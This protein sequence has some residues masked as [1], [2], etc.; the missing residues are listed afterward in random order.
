MPALT[1][2]MNR[3]SRLI[4]PEL[5]RVDE[6]SRLE[7]DMAECKDFLSRKAEHE[8]VLQDWDAKEAALRADAARALEVMPGLADLRE[9]VSGVHAACE[10][11]DQKVRYKNTLVH[12]FCFAMGFELRS[13]SPMRYSSTDDFM[14][15]MGMRSFVEYGHLSRVQERYERSREVLAAFRREVE[16]LLLASDVNSVLAQQVFFKNAQVGTK[17]QRGFLFMTEKKQVPV[18]KRCEMDNIEKMQVVQEMLGALD[19]IETNLAGLFAA[20]DAINANLPAVEALR[21][22]ENRVK[23]AR[24]ELEGIPADFAGQAEQYVKEARQRVQSLKA[25]LV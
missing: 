3:V 18:I 5:R 10:F 20:R 8:R 2:T 14:W 4:D 25:V 19:V 17:T 13:L 6:I 21:D 9:Q 23:H 1:E 15:M 12:E 22:A 11:I 16:G 24:K 7:A